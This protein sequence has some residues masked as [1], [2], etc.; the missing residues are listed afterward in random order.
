MWQRR[1]NRLEIKRYIEIIKL[2]FASF[3]IDSEDSDA[4][5]TLCTELEKI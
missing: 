1:G 2:I 3:E 4:L 5:A